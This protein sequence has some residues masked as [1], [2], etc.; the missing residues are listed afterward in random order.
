M[1]E[2]GFG[3]VRFETDENG[4]LSLFANATEKSFGERVDVVGCPT[5]DE[6]RGFRTKKRGERT[7]DQSG[8]LHP[9][10][11][12]V[13]PV[14]ELPCSLADKDDSGRSRQDEHNSSRELVDEDVGPSFPLGEVESFGVFLIQVLFILTGR[15]C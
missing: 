7:V 4:Q 6:I 14:E 11:T 2:S 13:I 5:D 15:C 9:L 1:V 10:D 8:E 3:V 12:R